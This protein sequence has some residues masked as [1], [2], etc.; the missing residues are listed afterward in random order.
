[1]R[2]LWPKGHGPGHFVGFG[3]FGGTTI[4]EAEIA[5]MLATQIVSITTRNGMSFPHP[6][7][8]QNN[9]LQSPSNTKSAD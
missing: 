6:G 7:R 9:G 3:P 1:V 5:S 2:R 4:A 8:R